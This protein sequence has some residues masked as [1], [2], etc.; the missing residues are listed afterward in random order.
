V[1]KCPVYLYFSSLEADHIRRDAKDGNARYGAVHTT[2]RTKT[3]TARGQNVHSKNMWGENGKRSLFQKKIVLRATK[4]TDRR[5]PV[6][7]PVVLE[8][9]VSRASTTP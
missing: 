2:N 4:S 5:V 7:Q 1:L 3:H 8:A 6:P 9:T